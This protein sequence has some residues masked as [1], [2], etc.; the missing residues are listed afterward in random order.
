MRILVT[1]GGTSEN[2]DGI[3]KLTNTSTGK[4]GIDIA[5]ELYSLG[6]D[7]KLLRSKNSIADFPGNQSSFESFDDLNDLFMQELEMK[8]DF[9]IHAAA[10]SDYKL[11]SISINGK[12]LSSSNKI[13]S[14]QKISLNLVPTSK[15]V[16]EVKKT[17]P[18]SKLLAF[19]FTKTNSEDERLE[20]V[21]KIIDRSG[22]DFVF[23]NDQNLKNENQH[24]FKI[25]NNKMN[26]LISG[27]SAD[28]VTR[29]VCNLVQESL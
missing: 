4:T 19:K 8:P 9:I 1:A 7:V 17:S 28:E 2:I 20:A 26:S 24:I 18:K 10:V 29:S 5:S 23:W 14:G 12:E 21:Q 6:H 22:A 15:I 13:K 16:D 27:N 3:R 25:Y 11:E